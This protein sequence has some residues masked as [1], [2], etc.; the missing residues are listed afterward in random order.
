MVLQSK[1]MHKYVHII[2]INIH[3]NKDTMASFYRLSFAGQSSTK[4]IRNNLSKYMRLHIFLNCTIYR[5]WNRHS[6]DMF[7]F[8]LV[9]YGYQESWCNHLQATK[10]QKYL[11][12]HFHSNFD[13]YSFKLHFH[14]SWAS[15]SGSTITWYK[16]FFIITSMIQWFH[17][18]PITRSCTPKS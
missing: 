17:L 13:N 9:K 11:H 8:F 2:Q 7:Q 14:S 12:S 6:C 1:E 15:D 10:L 3:T 5:W 16:T 4:R 18:K